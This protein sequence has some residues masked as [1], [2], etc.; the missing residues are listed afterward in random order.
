[1]AFDTS[2]VTS[3]SR[4]GVQS[5]NRCTSLA[6]IDLGTIDDV[7]GLN[8]DTIG[9]NAFQGCPPDGEI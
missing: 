4:I 2:I 7:G 6:K 5:F 3:L 9:N 1:V 8:T